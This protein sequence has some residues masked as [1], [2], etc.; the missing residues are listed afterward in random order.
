MNESGSVIDEIMED[1]NDNDNDN[2]NLSGERVSRMERQVKGAPPTISRK[3]QKSQKSHKSQKVVHFMEDPSTVGHIE[4]KDLSEY[5][6]L[7]LIEGKN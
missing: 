1:D 2:D 4:L 7:N 5:D 3:S 6:F